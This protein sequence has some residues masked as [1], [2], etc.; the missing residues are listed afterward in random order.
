MS[1]EDFANNFNKTQIFKF[2]GFI[3]FFSRTDSRR[4]SNF[5]KKMLS[6]ISNRHWFRT[7]SSKTHSNPKTVWRSLRKWRNW[8][9]SFIRW[10]IL[11]PWVNTLWR[12]YGSI[13]IK[14]FKNLLY[15][16]IFVQ[17]SLCIYL[18]KKKKLIRLWWSLF[19][20]LFELIKDKIVIIFCDNE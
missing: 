7:I 3:K 16:C 12:T 18:V 11:R 13:Q 2:K 9:H 14:D 6:F 17:L 10:F 1:T 15:N 5:E 8:R 19:R 20:K 4:I